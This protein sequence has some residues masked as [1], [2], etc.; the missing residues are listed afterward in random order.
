LAWTAERTS[1]NNDD[2]Y[3]QRYTASDVASGSVTAIAIGQPVSDNYD[4]GW[5][6][7][8]QTTAL[9]GGGYASTWS[10]RTD[11]AHQNY[12]RSFN[13][14]GTTRSSATLVGVSGNYYNNAPEIEALTDGGYVVAWSCMTQLSQTSE[15]DV[16]V[17]RFNAAGTAVSPRYRLAGDPSY[18]YDTNVKLMATA[19]DGY[20]VVFNG[21]GTT[22]GTNV[23]LQRYGADNTAQ[24]GSLVL[25]EPIT[26]AETLPEISLLTN[27][28][29][30]LVWTAWTSSTN[31][32]EIAVQVMNPDDTVTDHTLVN[33]NGIA[34]NYTDTEPVVAGLADGS[35]VVAWQGET[36]DGNGYDVFVQRFNQ[37]GT[38]LGST[39]RYVGMAGNLD[40]TDLEIAALEGGGFVLTW[41]GET[42]DSQGIDIFSQHFDSI[43]TVVAPSVV[44]TT[45]ATTG[46][47]GNTLS[48]GDSVEVTVTFDEMVHVDGSPRIQLDIGGVLVWATYQSGSASTA[49]VFSYTIQA[50]E[51]D[52]NGVSVV[53]DSLALNAGNIRSSFNYL[54][55]FSHSA[56]LTHSGVPND[57]T[58][59][60]DTSTPPIVL[61]LNGDGQL[62]YST[63]H[64]DVS[65]DGVAE[66]TGWVG[67]QDGL[68]VWDQ[69]GDGLIHDRSQFV[70]SQQPGQSDLQGL[71]AQFDANG[72]GVFD[73]NDPFFSE[74]AAW[75]DSNQNGV[76]DLGEIVKLADLG[77]V[78]VGLSTDG[79]TRVPADN[80]VEVGQGEAILANGQT[81]LLADVGFSYVVLVDEQPVL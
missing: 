12:V 59:L 68:L 33:L 26:G 20:I 46:A 60:V 66:Q 41:R 72:D 51:S 4:P 67:P 5:D 64:A 76:A 56:D 37:D 44:S 28:D 62:E 65:G 13:A 3:I 40:D 2:V 8:T 71:A 63:I 31:S 23:Y 15:T 49:L 55:N 7:Y 25:I 58:A 22:G 70:F 39:Q 54:N 42:S 73:G 24:H 34:G 6:R 80:V 1:P 19:D 75:Q 47:V 27:G 53:A 38:T 32:Y 77:V 17:Q 81:M 52:T 21:R 30:V 69:F 43:G 74:F 10:F 18:G 36:D 57:A 61:D 78:S 14:D 9:F 29:Y 50:G 11:P 79:V 35:F 16:F 45:I 48:V